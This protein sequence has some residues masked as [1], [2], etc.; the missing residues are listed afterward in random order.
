MRIPSSAGFDAR[1]EEESEQDRRMYSFALCATANFDTEPTIQRC[2]G[3]R[4]K[5]EA[6]TALA[7][8]ATLAGWNE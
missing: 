7:D 1:R 2:D 6:G 8:T 4:L 3:T 5:P